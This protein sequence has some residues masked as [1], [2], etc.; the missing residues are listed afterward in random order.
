MRLPIVARTLVLA[1]VAS[2]P[3]STVRG[4]IRSRGG[5]GP[6]RPDTVPSTRVV[7]VPAVDRYD[8]SWV[9][10]GGALK[11]LK[12]LAVYTTDGPVARG[13]AA[14]IHANVGGSLIPL[15]R[16]GKSA[17]DFARSLVDTVIE[18]TARRNM[19]RA[20]V[21]IAEP[22]LVRPFIRG[23]V[24]GRNGNARDEGPPNATYIVF[25]RSDNLRLLS[26]KP[27]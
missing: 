23:A 4:Q 12:V 17:E 11:D 7:L 13:L 20:I 25:V 27:F 1:A 14:K 2:I 5:G 10:A 8:A 19:N 9:A 6:D 3:F 22:D 16:A 18:K 26:A 24:P 21:V 15:E